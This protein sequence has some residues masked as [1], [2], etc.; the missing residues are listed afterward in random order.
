M[1][2]IIHASGA[3]E[4]LIFITFLWF[5]FIFF[6]W[7]IVVAGN[8]E[9]NLIPIDPLHLDKFDIIQSENS[10]VNIKL[11]LRNLTFKGVKDIVV[12]KVM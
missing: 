12:D 7:F 8:K 4:M 2:S 3:G 6:Y 1:T 11:N 5:I 10:P 9:L